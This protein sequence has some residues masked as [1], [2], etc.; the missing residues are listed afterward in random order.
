[1]QSEGSHYTS[2]VAEFIFKFQLYNDQLKKTFLGRK[3]SCGNIVLF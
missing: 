3:N 1:M 2:K